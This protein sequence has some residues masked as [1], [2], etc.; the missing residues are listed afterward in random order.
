MV[1]KR[2][3]QAFKTTGTIFIDM[4]KLTFASLILGALL[5]GDVDQLLLFVFGVAAVAIL[6]VVGILLVSVSEE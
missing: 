3:H 2:L 4:G 5:K 1:N 6:F